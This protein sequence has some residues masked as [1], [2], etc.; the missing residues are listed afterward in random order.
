METEIK[1]AMEKV[2]KVDMEKLKIEME[3]VKEELQEQKLNMKINSEQIKEEVNQAM[4]K[5]KVSIE[6]AKEELMLYKSF[7][8]ELE[9]DGLIDKK[10]SYKIEIKEG[11]LFINDKKQ[12]KDVS[13]KY[14]H[15][16][17]KENFSIT[18]DGDDSI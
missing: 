15:Y 5:A 3:K 18:S 17:K 1:E 8:N 14:R 11:E 9:K 4:A 2:K 16:Y 6:N 13:D 12:P 10:K 7:T